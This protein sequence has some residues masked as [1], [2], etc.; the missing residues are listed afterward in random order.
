MKN[1]RLYKGLSRSVLVIM[2]IVTIYFLVRVLS[3]KSP[4]GIDQLDGIYCQPKQSIAVA[5]LG[6]SHVHC[7]INTGV[8][9]KEFGIPAYDYSGAEQP[10]WMTY[11]YLKELYK[12]QTPEVILLDLY[13]PARFKEDYQYEWMGENIWAMQFSLNKLQAL[14]VS[15][16]LHQIDNYFPSFMVY[17][18][19]YDDLE[20]A[21]FQ[22]F[23]WNEQDHV[24]F[25]GYTPYWNIRP[26][27]KEMLEET[28][29]IEGAGLTIKSEEYLRKIIQL[30]KEKES[31]LVLIV[32]PYVETQ[33]DKQTY[34]QIREIALEQDIAFIDFNESDKEI[35]LD[36]EA[37]FNDE[38]HL[39]Y[40]GSC[41][42]TR[43]LGNYLQEMLSC[44]LYEGEDYLSW[45]L[46]AELIEKE[47]ESYYK[48][49]LSRTE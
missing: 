43:Y 9:W 34:A 32:I 6:T 45:D 33:S 27:K 46:N 48:G 30:T 11:Y 14:L 21:D 1:K 15:V 19:R 44:Q 38:S 8:L 2:I 42:F 25:K 41:K 49:V 12:Y 4:H 47:E 5:A 40:W 22:N 3:L 23:F 17:H 13:A 18:S 39:N 28:S 10:L 26:Q 35:G 7:G 36:Y 29:K 16:E 24:A 37:D 31:E 20:E